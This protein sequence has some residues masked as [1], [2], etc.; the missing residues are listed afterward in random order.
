MIPLPFSSPLL[1][2]YRN[3]RDRTLRG[4][5]LFIAEGDL[6]VERL[7]DSRFSV[8]SVMVVDRAVPRVGEM[9]ERKVPKGVPIYVVAFSE[10]AELVG[11]PFHQGVLAV[12]RREA[13]WTV[14]NL[15][16]EVNDSRDWSERSE[17][18]DRIEPSDRSLFPEDRKEVGNHSPSLSGRSASL[19]EAPVPAVKSRRQCIVV[20]PDVTKPDNLGN[21]FRCSAA[22]GASGI[23]LG[24]QACDPLSRR[25]MRVSMGG[26]MQMPWAKS[27]N[28]A[29]DL[30]ILKGRYGYTIYGTVIDEN[31]QPLREVV[32]AEKSVLCFGNEYT[33]LT[34]EVLEFCDM[35]VTIPM[36]RGVDS[37]NLGVSA[38]IF[39]Y[40]LMID[41]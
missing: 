9:L 10:V 15:T 7:L 25:A 37:L 11:F 32:W 4:E 40:E 36:S 22:L 2:P 18:N 19:R 34:P 28:L 27:E 14:D 35:R 30:T 1:D 26:V 41:N 21:V 16:A 24:P 39:L 38:G 33:G 6:V 8:E 3:M 23:L 29:E 31:A 5:S 13:L 12:G 20:M 17:R